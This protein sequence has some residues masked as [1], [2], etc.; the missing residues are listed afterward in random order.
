MVAVALAGLAVSWWRRTLPDRRWWIP[1]ALIAPAILFLQFPVSDFLWNTLPKMRFLQFP[2]RWLVVLEAP[3]AIFFASALWAGRRAWRVLAAAACAVVFVAASVFAFVSLF[4]SCDEDDRV[5]GILRDYR[6]GVG[7]EGT[8]EYAPPSADDSLVATGLPFACLVAN[9]A[10]KLGQGDPDMTPDWW[11]EQDSCDATWAADTKVE[12]PQH[13]RLLAEVPRAG[14][15]VLRLRTY[16]AWR[17]RVNGQPPGLTPQRDDGLM[18]IPVPPG[19][20]DLTADWT[21]TPDVI[22]GRLITAAALALITLLWLFGR[23]RI[24]RHLS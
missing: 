11:P 21:T 23:R 15:L 4:Q 13:L 18:A 16:P 12:S 24:R 8:D 1:L 6:G 2:W 14:Y 5:T 20:V 10:I 3:M 22:V 7:F 17:V 19:R 9:P